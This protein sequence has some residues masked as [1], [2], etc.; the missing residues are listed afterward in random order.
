MDV[1]PLMC[2]HVAADSY[3][4]HTMVFSTFLETREVCGS[5]SLKFS[6]TFQC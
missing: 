2:L 1:N 3:D 4:F 5:Q 6:K